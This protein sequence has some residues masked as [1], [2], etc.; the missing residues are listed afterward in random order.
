MS[1]VKFSYLYRDG[2]NTE[3]LASVVFPNP[4]RMS[5]PEI[6]KTIKSNLV[7]GELF[8]ARAWGLVPLLFKGHDEDRDQ[9]WNAFESV[10]VTNEQA[11]DGRSIGRF[12]SSLSEL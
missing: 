4:E 1:N 10:E 6:E 7:G 5:I 2:G 9:F 12:I 11:L 8:D 3:C